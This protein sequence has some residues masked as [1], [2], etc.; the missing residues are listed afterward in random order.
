[1]LICEKVMVG[2]VEVGESFTIQSKSDCE[3]DI[4]TVSRA[5]IVHL[6]ICSKVRF[7]ECLLPL[8]Q[9]FHLDSS[10]I[11]IIKGSILLIPSQ[12]ERSKKKNLL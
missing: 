1:M 12:T 9:T 7:S 6:P 11:P 3:G 4:A 8:H 2:F 5:Q 10:N